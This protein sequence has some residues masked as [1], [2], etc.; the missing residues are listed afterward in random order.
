ME[1]TD[2]DY[3]LKKQKFI[4]CIRTIGTDKCPE[5]CSKCKYDISSED[6]IH[7]LVHGVDE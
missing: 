2:S 5:D 7:F 6:F 1:K 3:E 4:K